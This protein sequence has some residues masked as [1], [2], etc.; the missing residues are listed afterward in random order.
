VHRNIVATYSHD[1]CNVVSETNHELGI[2]K[3]YL[4]QVRSL[5]RNLWYKS[6]IGWLSSVASS[7]DCCDDHVCRLCLQG[8]KAGRC[9]RSLSTNR[10]ECE[11]TGQHVQ[12][13]RVC[14]LSAAGAAC[15]PTSW[16]T[17]WAR[18]SCGGGLS[19]LVLMAEV[20]LRWW[21][22]CSCTG[23]QGA[24]AVVA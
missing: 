5:L 20:L 8:R 21:L 1:I 4:I 12:D 24:V 9:S 14:S 23:G 11:K 7:S 19:V 16:P 6:T 2:F 22:E 17:S 18:C 13:W 10:C 15:P 3:F